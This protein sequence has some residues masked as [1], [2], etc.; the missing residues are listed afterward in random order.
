MGKKQDAAR[1]AAEKIAS[2]EAYAA[3]LGSY[4]AGIEAQLEEERRLRARDSADL[5]T[6]RAAARKRQQIEAEAQRR[7]ER[8]LE[9]KRL[10]A[11]G[12]GVID[13]KTVKHDIGFDYDADG[14]G[15]TVTVTLYASA[16]EA[17]ILNAFATRDLKDVSFAGSIRDAV[18]ALWPRGIGI[19]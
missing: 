11:L 17:K 13:L 6:Y 2:L 14:V 10:E 5:E 7:A 4:N 19:V 15:G 18:A 3:E 12:E 9:R 1:L 8:E 16:A